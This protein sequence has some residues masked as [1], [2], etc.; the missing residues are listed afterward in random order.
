MDCVGTR[1][2]SQHVELVRGYRDA[3][4][5]VDRS[6]AVV[7]EGEC[8]YRTVGGVVGAKQSR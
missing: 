7:L 5:S 1:Y 2:H 3:D 6:N 8:V 4:R